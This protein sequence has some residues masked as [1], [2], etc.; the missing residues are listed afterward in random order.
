MFL[1]SNPNISIATEDI[2]FGDNLTVKVTTPNDATGNLTVT[3]SNQ[4]QTLSV[5]SK[6]T[7]FNFTNLKANNYDIQIIYSGDD[8]YLN[9]TIHAPVNVA[10][11]D[12]NTLI[13]LSTIVVGEDL[14]IS[15]NVNAD[16]SG[17]VTLY[18]NNNVE[19]LTLADAF[20]NYTIESI[21][22]GDYLI[23]AVY[24]GDDKYL[25]STDSKFIEVDNLNA[26][27]EIIADN[28]TYGNPAIIQIKLNT[29]AEGNVSVTIDGVTNSSKVTEG[30]AE[31][32][33]YNLDAGV[34]K[35]IM[36]FY[37][38]DD[39]Y[40]NL[41]ENVTFTINKA[42]LT[43]NITSSDIMIGQNAIIK[44]SVPKKTAGTFTIGGTIFNI[45]FSGEVEFIIEDLEIGDYEY[46]AIYNGNNYNTI[47]N[48]TSFR[49]LEYPAPQWPNE[50]SN[51]EN[52]GQSPYGGDANGEVAWFISSDDN[53]IGNLVI[54][55]EG[56]IYIATASLIYS[57]N[58]AGDLRWNFTSESREG[59]FS[60]LCIGRDV[61]IS[62]KSGDT[63]YFINQTDGYKYG[64]SNLYQGSS[65]FAPIID[66]NANLY[67]ASEYQ[68]DSGS[69]KLVKIPYKSWEFGGE[70]QYVDLGKAQPVTAPVANEDM[71][72]VLSEGRLR[73]IDA[74]T[75]KTLFIKSGNYANVKPVIG[76]G[77]IVYAVL[78]DSIVAY[79]ISGSQLWKTKVTGGIGDKLVLDSE[80]GL[81]SINSKG[82]L[83]RYDSITGKESLIS[84][85]EITSG[86][87]VG[88]NGNLYLASDKTFYELNSKGEILWKS[89]LSSKITGNPVMD[90]N[91][92]I[93]VTSSDNKI[94]A[95]TY[96][97]LKDSNLAVTV[98][99]YEIKITLDNETTGNLYFTLNG[100][101]YENV[102]VKDIS[103]LNAGK[104]RIN[105][106]YSG[107]MRFNST[108]KIVDFTVKANET[109]QIESTKKDTISISLPD[110]ATG[111]LTVIAGNATYTQKLS[112]GKASI[113]IT[114]LDSMGKVSIIYSGDNKYYGFNKTV[115]VTSTKVKL[116]GYNVSVL[117]SSNSY[118]KVRLTQNSKALVG[119]SI[120]LTVNGK[121]VK[122]N[123]DK[124]GYVSLKIT[125]PPKTY[126]VT[127]QYGNL[128]IQNKITVKS[129]IFAKNINAKKSAKKLKVKVALKKVNGKFLKGKKVKLKFNKKN[130]K[131]KTNKKGIVTFTIKK[132]VYKKLKVGK[133]Y[134]YQ[135]IY[136][137]DT[138]K[139]TI[140]FKK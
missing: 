134:T 20:A 101:R 44:I 58:N 21:P 79:S 66:S 40:F 105:V 94:F 99:D 42:D 91:G 95:L 77:N 102:F 41:T 39:T 54:D 48:S 37:T 130:F 34:N 45:P 131:A 14:V 1:K 110:D 71:I 92:R 103:D 35:N 88:R 120:I 127:V 10:K 3:V 26:T 117:Y 56:N 2:M 135:V 133:R 97:D 6:T 85:L 15:I 57:I 109:A 86:I 108:S 62:P 9:Q 11:Y 111:N 5:M 31:I 114:G 112:N 8:K 140:K 19:T 81:Y 7:V 124:N 139:K 126:K 22:R 59:N 27:M 38:G 46:S 90:E 93:Y 76:N 49:V 47:S 104:Y 4:T 65:L 82:N 30:S 73:V 17:N 72:V 113:S 78:G 53:I 125:L 136:G 63:L 52:T 68:Y 121:T 87:L 106:T 55:S 12:S 13:S 36:V 64:S 80:R 16:A 51:S 129:I 74:K 60:G 123:T 23:K 122:V 18:I 116:T 132:N 28:I 69:Y 128:K 137:K 89:V 24:N 61:I 107:D 70:I 118:Y 43:F 32:Y 115:D 100:V 119:K 83:Y 29:N 67:I 50:G 138:V 25:N 33:I 98:N 84:N 96:A 75:L